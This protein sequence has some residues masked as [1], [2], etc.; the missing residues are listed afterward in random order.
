[1]KK[2]GASLRIANY[3]MDAALG[4]NNDIQFSYKLVKGISK[5]KAARLILIQMGFPDEIV[6]L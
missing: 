2:S 1:V 3:K 6:G 4:T 5:I